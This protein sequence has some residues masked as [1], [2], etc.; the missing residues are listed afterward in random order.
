M[1]FVPVFSVDNMAA[2][3]PNITALHNSSKDRRRLVPVVSL[4]NSREKFPQSSQRTST[5]S[6]WSEVVTCLFL[7]QSPEREGQYYHGWFGSVRIYSLGSKGARLLLNHVTVQYL[8][9]GVPLTKK[10]LFLR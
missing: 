5:G 10:G 6:H 2:I 9:I 4:F 7:K 3:V 8:K 1:A